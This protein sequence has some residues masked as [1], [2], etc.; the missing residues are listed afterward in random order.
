[1][2]SIAYRRIRLVNRTTS[3]VAKMTPHVGICCELIKPFVRRLGISCDPHAIR[4]RVMVCTLLSNS[5]RVGEIPGETMKFQEEVRTP[6]FLPSSGCLW[7]ACIVSLIRMYI[8]YL[9]HT[10]FN[11]YNMVCR[12]SSTIRRPNTTNLRT[13]DFSS[14]AV[15][16]TCRPVETLARCKTN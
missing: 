6:K 14:F 7:H 15:Y 8:F 10:L 13:T 1:M 9:L 2:R 3:I 12:N 11:N 16:F 4:P 5:I